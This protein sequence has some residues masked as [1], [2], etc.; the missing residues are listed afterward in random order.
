MSEVTL[1]IVIVNWNGKKILSDCLDTLTNHVRSENYEVIVVDN[2]STDGSVKMAKEHLCP[3]KLIENSENT[4]FAFANNQGFEIA[5]GKYVLLLNSD[6]L[7]LGDVLQESVAYLDAHSEVGILGCR[8]LNSDLTMQRTCARQPSFL[9]GLLKTTG[10]HRLDSFFG[11]EHYARWQRDS[12]RN[13]GV[14]TGC[15]LMTRSSIIE[16]I[17][18]LDDQFFFN[19]EETDFCRRVSNA[20]WHVRF[21]P[22]GEIIHL[23]GGSTGK[24][25][26]WREINLVKGKIQFFMKHFGPVSAFLIWFQ[27]VSFWKI[28][29]LLSLLPFRSTQFSTATTVE[30]VQDAIKLNPVWQKL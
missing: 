14:V 10:L 21:S 15:Y 1:S 8:V 6:T 30:V 23:G 3:L 28:R 24:D 29:H 19:Y 17:G 26:A 9:M 18:G 25:N 20:G 5:S 7:V 4:G 11:F 27:V 2:G 22:V 13:V 12:E 16:E